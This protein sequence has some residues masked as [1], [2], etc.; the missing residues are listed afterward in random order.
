MLDDEKFKL[1]ELYKNNGETSLTIDM[2]RKTT[3]WFDDRELLIYTIPLHYFNGRISW[4][5]DVEPGSLLFCARNNIFAPT[6][7]LEK[8]M[9][10]KKPY[11]LI[12]LRGVEQW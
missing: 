6:H 10:I 12:M 4:N 9:G 5:P 1:I 11:R 8:A 3:D 7:V 2:F